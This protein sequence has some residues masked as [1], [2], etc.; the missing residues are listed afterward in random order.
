MEKNRL[1]KIILFS[2]ILSFAFLLGTES[3]P[4]AAGKPILIGGSLPQ[5]GRFAET[6]KWIQRGMEFWADEINGKAGLLGRKVEFKI[7]DDESSAAKAVTFAE[8]AITV[9]KVNLLFGGYPGTAARAVM[10]VAEKHKYVYVSM[11]GHM[12]SFQQGYTYSFGGPPLMGEWW[13][14]GFYQWMRTVPPDQRPTR[15]AVYTM[16]NP[17]GASL[18]D[19]IFRMSKELNIKLVINEKYNLP[20]PD[21]TPLV[22]KAKQMN[23]DILFSNGFFADGV[24]TLRAA[25][26]LNYNPKAIVQGVGS[27]IP[28]WLKELGEDGYYVFSGTSLHNKLNYPGNDKLNAFIKKKYNIPGYPVYFGFGYA[29]MQTLSQGVEGAKSLDQTT[30]RDWLKSNTVNTICGPMSFDDKGLPDPINFCTQ[31]IDGQ[32]E[33]IWPK[34]IRTA[35]PVYPKPKW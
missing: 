22:V 32:V 14:E 30:I 18:T 1:K 33:L 17:I 8:K 12:K 15:A 10:P 25:K 13:Y 29:W 3:A 31:V 34:E 20:L 21:A 23:C 27:V 11:G 16:N 5:T 4:L 9:D 19:S 6:A 35:K 24:M 7:Y 28:A 2:F 26:A